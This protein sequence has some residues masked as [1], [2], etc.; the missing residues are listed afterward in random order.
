M[1]PI[2]PHPSF[3][4]EVIDVVVRAGA[5]ALGVPTLVKRSFLERLP[6]RR[7]TLLI[8]LNDACTLFSVLLR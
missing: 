1:S 4:A 5:L 3:R 7:P 8:V 6:Q 2:F